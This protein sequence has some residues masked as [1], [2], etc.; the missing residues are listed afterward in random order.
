MS[1]LG[2]HEKTGQETKK[3][4]CWGVTLFRVLLGF[5]LGFLHIFVFFVLVCTQKR[6][7]KVGTSTVCYVCTR[8]STKLYCCT[9]NIGEI[10]FV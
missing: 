6:T 5:R 8:C 2:S 1:I 4:A 10:T 9:Q 3:L 7:L